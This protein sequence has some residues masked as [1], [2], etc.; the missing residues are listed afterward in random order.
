LGPGNSKVKGEEEKVG[1]TKGEW[2]EEE[3]VVTN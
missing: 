2:V 1:E 3:V